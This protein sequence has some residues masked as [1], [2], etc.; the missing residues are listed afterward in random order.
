[1][2]DTEF[3]RKKSPDTRYEI[4]DSREQSVRSDRAELGP[5]QK[6]KGA[7]AQ[8]NPKHVGKFF[9]TQKFGSLKCQRS[10]P[11]DR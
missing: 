2:R 9:L 3:H 6:K 10:L 8:T 4:R 7:N 11:R 1:M 5:E